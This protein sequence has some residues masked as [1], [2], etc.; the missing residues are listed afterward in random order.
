MFIFVGGYFE[1][2]STEIP[3]LSARIVI[4]IPGE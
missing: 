4:I 1:P 2:K 3:Y